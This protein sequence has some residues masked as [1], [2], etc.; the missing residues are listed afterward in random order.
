MNVQLHCV[1]SEYSHFSPSHHMLTH[2][3]T[4][5]Y[6][7]MHMC[8]CTHI[9]THVLHAHTHTLMKTENGEPAAI[10]LHAHVHISAH[11]NTCTCTRTHTHVF[12]AHTHTQPHTWQHSDDTHLTLAHFKKDRRKSEEP[13]VSEHIS[14]G[15]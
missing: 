4:S 6:L 9:H 8:T 1:F 3:C 2:K 12:H 11:T 13:N 10:V 14:R 5:M 15:Q 7:Y